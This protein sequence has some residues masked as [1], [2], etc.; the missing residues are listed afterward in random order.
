MKP[1][2]QID[3]GEMVHQV[4]IL[5]QQSVQ[6]ISGT[7]V[8]WVPSARAWAAINP[9]RGT[10]VIRGGQDTTKLYLFVTIRWQTGIVPNMRVQSLNGTY[11]IQAIENPGERNVLLVLTCLGLGANQ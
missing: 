6:D 10:D 5:Q 4:I 3:P 11:V 7:S 2:P 1:W 8:A 9:V